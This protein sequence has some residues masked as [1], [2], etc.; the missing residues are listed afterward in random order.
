MIILLLFLYPMLGANQLVG[1]DLSQAVPLTL[2]AAVGALIFGHVELDVTRLAGDRQRAGRADRLAVLASTAPDRYVRPV[3]TFVIAA[4][5]LKYV[6]PA[7]KNW[8]GTV[9]DPRR[10]GRHVALRQAAVADACRRDVPSDAPDRCHAASRPRVM[11][12]NG[13]VKRRSG[14]LALGIAAVYDGPRVRG[15]GISTFV[16]FVGVTM[17]DPCGEQGGGR[18]RECRDW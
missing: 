6:G 16:G 10:G 9:R 14:P 18:R 11:A 1:T 5:G 12:K 8:L 3:I 2:A 15:H 13:F 7:P 17:W 4:S